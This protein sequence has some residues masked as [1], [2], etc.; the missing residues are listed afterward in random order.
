[1]NYLYIVIPLISA[2]IGWVTNFIAVK[3]IFRPRL[4]VSILG[5]RLQGLIPKHKEDLARKIGETVEK[6]L[7]SHEDLEKVVNSAEFQADIR[8]SI[9]EKVDSFITRSFGTN[10]MI[11]LFLQSDAGDKV[12]AQ[13]VKEI[14][15]LIPDTTQALLTKLN[16]RVDFKKIVTEKIMAFDISRFEAIIQSIAARELKAIEIFG[17][18][19]GFTVGLV[20]VGL[21]IATKTYG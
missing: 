15:K 21:L 14:E 17:G 4:P 19:L 9:M 6:E 5:V 8:D 11:A 12:R 20:Q 1:V 10:P 3:M 16:D 2:L 18:V 7:I 13:F